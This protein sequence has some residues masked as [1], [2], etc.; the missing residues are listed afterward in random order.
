[1]SGAGR[2]GPE[3]G[4]GV[5]GVSPGLGAQGPVLPTGALGSVLPTGPGPAGTHLQTR[6]T[7]GAWRGQCWGVGGFG[8]WEFKLTSNLF[9]PPPSA[10]RPKFSC[11]GWE[12]AA[13]APATPGGRK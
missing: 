10:P 7:Q 12:K 6:D 3:Q 13:L 4:A 9:L 2:E 8:K 11:Q 5:G 1:M